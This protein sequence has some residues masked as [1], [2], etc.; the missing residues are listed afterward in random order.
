[1]E[2]DKRVEKCKRTEKGREPLFINQFYL[3]IKMCLAKKSTFY[4][5][6][7]TTINLCNIFVLKKEKIVWSQDMVF[8]L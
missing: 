5:M 8:G 6:G 7:H 4:I 3:I 2:G 1:M